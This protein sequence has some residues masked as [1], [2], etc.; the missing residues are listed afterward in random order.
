MSRHIPNIPCCIGK[1][2]PAACQVE[3]VVCSLQCASSELLSR[4]ASLFVLNVLIDFFR[5]KGTG[6]LLLA[7]F[8]LYFCK[9]AYMLL[10]SNKGRFQTLPP[11]LLLAKGAVSCM[12]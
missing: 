10:I 7:C 6:G 5:E 8:Y 4:F 1:T 2:S 3:V 12:F 11:S 9:N